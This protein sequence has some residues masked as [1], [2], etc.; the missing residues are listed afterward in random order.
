VTVT[1]NESW[2]DFRA[3]V[4]QL[5]LAELRWEWV[6]LM[7]AG[8]RLVRQCE[9]IAQQ[10]GTTA[11]VGLIGA[12]REIDRQWNFVDDLLLERDELTSR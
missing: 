11:S 1:E 6:L 5:P 2:D 8:R 7:A 10:G 3:R 12:F 9:L 4:E